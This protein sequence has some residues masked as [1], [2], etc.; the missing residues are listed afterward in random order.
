MGLEFIE[1]SKHLKFFRSWRN[2]N[3]PKN[4]F[5]TVVLEQFGIGVPCHL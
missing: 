3:H 1:I 5:A 4:E 2:L